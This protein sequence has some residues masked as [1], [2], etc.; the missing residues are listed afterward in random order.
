MIIIFHLKKYLALKLLFQ[1]F[2]NFNLQNIMIHTEFLLFFKIE[3]CF[4]YLDLRRSQP[5][6]LEKFTNKN[7]MNFILIPNTHGKNKGVH[8]KLL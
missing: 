7:F 1:K 5:E 4:E 8:V 3:Y 6:N 2:I